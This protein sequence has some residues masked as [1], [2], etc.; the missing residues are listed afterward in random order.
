MQLHLVPAENYQPQVPETD[1]PELH[2]IHG[3]GEGVGMPRPEGQPE[4]HIVPEPESDMPSVES[5]MRARAARQA[6][7]VLRIAT[8][9]QAAQP[10]DNTEGWRKRSG[11]GGWLI[12]EYMKKQAEAKAK[13]AAE[14]HESDCSCDGCQLLSA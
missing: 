3:G 5:L 4:L 10:A 14:G 13:A 11:G 7:R 2:L 8:N 1:G 6:G 12:R 9:E